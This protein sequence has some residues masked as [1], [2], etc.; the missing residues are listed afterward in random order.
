MNN[1]NNSI[2]NNETKFD[3]TITDQ[4]DETTKNIVNLDKKDSVQIKSNHD[5]SDTNINHISEGNKISYFLI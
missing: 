3:K 4:K 1:N 2:N 5:N